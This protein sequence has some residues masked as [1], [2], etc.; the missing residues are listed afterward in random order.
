[1]QLV[2]IVYWVFREIVWGGIRNAMTFVSPSA[3]IDK[4]TPLTAKRS[5]GTVLTPVHGFFAGGTLYG[6]F[7]HG[8]LFVGP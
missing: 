7:L 6:F 3:E 4:A 2:I 5:P 1:M 8:F